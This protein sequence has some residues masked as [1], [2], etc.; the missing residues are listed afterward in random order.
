V[1]VVFWS[2]AFHWVSDKLRH[3]VYPVG[4]RLLHYFSSNIRFEMSGAKARKPPG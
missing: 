2:W 1:V 3:R 4:N